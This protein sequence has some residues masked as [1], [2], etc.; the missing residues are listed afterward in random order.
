MVEHGKGWVNGRSNKHRFGAFLFIPAK[1]KCQTTLLELNM[2]TF[3]PEL[4][5]RSFQIEPLRVR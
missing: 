4:T 3:Y 5:W 1:A 2:F